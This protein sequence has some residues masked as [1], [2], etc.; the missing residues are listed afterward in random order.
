MLLELRKLSSNAPE[1]SPADIGILRKLLQWLTKEQ[2]VSS[3]PDQDIETRLL[4]VL[5]DKNFIPPR[6]SLAY[7]LRLG[8]AIECL[9]KARPDMPTAEDF[10][11]Q[12]A[13]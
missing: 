5:S 2:G 12:T 10:P 13:K 3:L 8:Y 11:Q 1:L 9:T 7:Q 4:A 6:S